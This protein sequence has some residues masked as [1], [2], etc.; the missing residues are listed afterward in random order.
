MLQFFFRIFFFA[1]AIPILSCFVT[2]TYVGLFPRLYAPNGQVPSKALLTVRAT[3]LEDFYDFF[4]FSLS[5]KKRR[6]NP[7]RSV[8]LYTRQNCTSKWN[9]YCNI[10]Y[11]DIRYKAQHTTRGVHLLLAPTYDFAVQRYTEQTKRR[12]APRVRGLV[13]SD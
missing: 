4:I 7:V 12:A 5:T 10:L 6:E 3:F 9:M 13:W 2:V 1:T 11:V 8:T